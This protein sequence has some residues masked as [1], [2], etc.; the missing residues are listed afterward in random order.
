MKRQKLMVIDGNSILNRAFYGL[1]GT[2]LLATSDGLYTNAVFGFINIMNK[3]IEEENP[4]YI[5]VAFDLKAPTFRHKQFD[6]YKANRKGMPDEL[7]VQ[8]PVIKEVLDAMCIKRLEMEGFEADDILGSIS[9]CAQ[10]KDI[11]VIIIT[12]DRDALQLAG[13]GTRIKIPKTKGGKTETEEYDYNTIREKYSIDPVQFIDVKA[14]MGDTSDNIP[15]VPGVGEKTALDLIKTYNSLENLYDNLEQITKKGLKEKLETYK[16]QAFMSKNLAAIDRNMP[17]LCHFDEL[18][19]NEFD[20]PKLYEL[21]RRLEF[22]SFIDKFGLRD[23]QP[24]HNCIAIETEIIDDGQGV[25]DLKQKI[26]EAKEVAFYYLIDRIDKFTNKLAGLCVSIKE[27]SSYFLNINERLT[28]NEFLEGFKSIFEDG[29]IKKYGHDLKNF[30]VY[31]KQNG[32]ELNGVAFDTMIGAYIIN[33]SRETYTISELAADFLNTNVKPIEEMAGKGK[34]FLPFG[35]MDVEE[36]KNVVGLYPEIIYKAMKK[37]DDK[38]NENDQLNLYYKIELPLVR[39]LADMEFYG[40]KININELTVIS[41]QLDEKINQLTLKIYELAGEEFNINS[42]KQLGVVLF[43]KLELPIIKKTKT[44]YSTDAEVL[45]ELAE[46]HEIVSNILEY[47]QLVKL[48]STYIEGLMAVINPHTGKIHS[49]FNQTVTVT[50][51]ISSTE[52][53]LQNIPIKLEMGRNIRKAFVPCDGNYKLVD[54]DYSQIELRVLAHI[55]DDE[56]MIGAFNN[57]E[58]IHT[59]TASKVFGV[60]NEEV[61]SALRSKAKAVNFGIV[62]GIGDFSLSKDLGITRKEARNYID[63]YLDKY[64]NVRK[65]M[66]DIVA[67]GK[68]FGFVTT[69][70]NRRRYLPELKASNFNVRSFGERIAMNTP[71]QGSAA[72]IIKIAMVMVHSELNRRQLKSRLILQVHD[73]LIIEAHESELEEVTM[74]LKESMENATALKVPLSVDVKSGNSWYETK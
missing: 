25:M 1:Q 56:N 21:F 62:Y 31:L 36:L 30:I 34:S 38:L 16:E 35:S 54:A 70:F 7:R 15:G 24:C 6:G 50:G 47:R 43:E 67:Q 9:L 42:P 58:D 49:S 17:F 44:G 48:K 40:F 27:G 28:E 26:H 12:G 66:H 5:C 10:E 32:I 22:K 23:S 74:I 20:K 53:N 46:K 2:N 3:Y 13:K 65:Y 8:V 55:T 71:I 69:M 61:T 52:P 64:A 63:G 29:E 18:V 60:P 45:E 68:E 37:I 57:N 4:Q 33:P 14:L 11:D 19:R 72:D 59:S 51:R 73:E 39:V 41:R